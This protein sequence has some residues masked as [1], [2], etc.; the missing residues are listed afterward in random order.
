MFASPASP[1]PTPREFEEGM[2]AEVGAGAGRG[3][4]HER[5][6]RERGW[7]WVGGCRGYMRVCVA[8]VGGGTVEFLKVEGSVYA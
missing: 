7:G 4:G 8:A 3:L 6:G 2:G 1:R 5:G